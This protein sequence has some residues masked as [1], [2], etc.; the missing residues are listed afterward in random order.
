MMTTSVLLPLLTLACMCS[1]QDMSQTL[2]T[3]SQWSVLT[4]VNSSD[5]CLLASGNFSLVLPQ[6]NEDN[7]SMVKVNRTWVVPENATANGV[8]GEKSSELNLHWID[9]D[10][11]KENLLNLV[12]TKVGRL[13]GLTG[14]FVRL[15]SG[16]NQAV[17]TEMS[18][19]IDLKNFNTLVWPIRYGLSCPVSLQFPLYHTPNPV[20]EAL[21]SS[22]GSVL[23][24]ESNHPTPMA[25]LVVENVKLEAFREVTLLDQDPESMS[26]EF[27]RQKWECEFHMTLDWAPIAVGGGLACLVSFMLG[28]FLCK[29]SIGCGDGA[30]RG[31]YEKV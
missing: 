27:Y 4:A 28:A 26:Q 1:S 6:M 10:T 14:I 22:S 13:A 15:Y 31:K 8:C 25:Y 5:H 12:I 20:S 30:R 7:T 11:G 23:S 24:Q 18:S 29:T 3:P 21:A 17:V 2:L 16:A 19:Q 9:Q